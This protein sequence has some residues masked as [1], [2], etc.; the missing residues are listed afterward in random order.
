[1]TS[2]YLLF[3]SVGNSFINE[4]IIL[5]KMPKYIWKCPLLVAYLY[6]FNYLEQRKAVFEKLFETTTDELTNSCHFDMNYKLLC[7]FVCLCN[8]LDNASVGRTYEQPS[9]V[10]QHK[11][12]GKRSINQSS[13]PVQ[14]QSCCFSWCEEGFMYCVSPDQDQMRQHCKRSMSDLV[15]FPEKE[16]ELQELRFSHW[17]IIQV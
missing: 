8:S 6:W 7:N 11:T 2:W 5:P 4:S 10:R 3:I 17:T 14:A 16:E 13:S 9:I 15:F 12:L 1:M